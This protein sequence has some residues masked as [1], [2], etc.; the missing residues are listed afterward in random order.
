MRK[1]IIILSAVAF[2]VNIYTIFYEYRNKSSVVTQH[3]RKFDPNSDS[4][5]FPN[6]ILCNHE[7]MSE[8][9]YSKKDASSFF[10]F[11]E[12]N[13]LQNMSQVLLMGELGFVTSEEESEAA[14]G[15]FQG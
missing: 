12:L 13:K 6:V 5:F 15:F 10:S 9:V 14:K 11:N 2:A 8:S 4:R 7:S 1:F 3:T